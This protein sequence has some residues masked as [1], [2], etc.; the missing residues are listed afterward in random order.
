MNRKYLLLAALASAMT[1]SA[2]D[3]Y[4]IE[5]L[6]TSD[7]NGTARFVGMGG[8]MS[9]LGADLSTMS[10]NPAGMALYR[11]SDVAVTGASART[12]IR[13][14]CLATAPPK[15]RLTR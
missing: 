13:A 7:L 10:S 15:V 11:R 4:E 9:A 6:T 12:W 8:A 2:Q 3:V 14:T 1:V 5:N